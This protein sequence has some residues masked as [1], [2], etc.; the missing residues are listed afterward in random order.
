MQ[1]AAKAII[2][3]IGGSENV[4]AAT[5]CATR[6]RLV[7]HDEKRV[8]EN[9][10]EAIEEVKG[11]YFSN[12]QLQ[13]IIG[14]GT[15]NKVH[16]EL[17]K[18]TDLDE[19]SKDEVKEAANKKMNPI[20][21]FVKMLS[22]IFIPIIPAIVAGGLLMGIYNVLTAPDLF[23]D[24]QS[25]V[26]VYPQIED[27]SEMVNT[28]ANAAFV[29][30]PILIGFSATNRFGGNPYLGA[31]LAM[32]MVHPDLL[33]ANLYGEALVEDEVSYWNLFG[34]EIAQVGYQNTVLPILAA[35]YVLANL[36]R[37]FRKIVPSILDNLLTPLLTLLTSAI[38]TFILVG[39]LMRTG[40][41]LFTEGL[42]W[43][44][45]ATGFIGSAIFGFLYAPLVITGMHHS[46]IAVETQLLANISETGGSFIFPIASMANVAQG[47]AALAVIWITREAQMKSIAT[48]SGISGLLGITEPA[49]FG[50]NLKLRYPFIAAIIGAGI[51]SAYL[52]F[53]SVLSTAIGPAGLPGIIAISP[54]SIVNFIIGLLISFTTTFALTFVLAR[55]DRL[56]NRG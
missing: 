47:A 24:G 35:A 27:L 20:Q 28:F 10:L 9:K 32:I 37:L 16:K 25:L 3:A 51:A 41:D 12:G 55:R 14:T 29:F 33:D 50:V 39:P 36:E 52:G 31:A 38:V 54:E 4:S 44:Y 8:D 48:A 34:L 18:L 46:F 5:H 17:I 13:I 7:L 45:D 43:M 6:L 11:S 26:D 42:V 2:D 40:G 49:M 56:K 19:S 53:T 21:R 30:L 15:V 23:F 1:E 22:D